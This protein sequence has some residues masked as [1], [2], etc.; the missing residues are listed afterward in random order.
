MTIE[1]DIAVDGSGNFYY[2]GAVH[3]ATGAGYYTVIEFHRYAQNL[4]DDATA[5][6][7]DLIDIT[8]ATPSDRSTDNIINILTGYTLDD[9]HGSA[10]DAISE[11]LYDGS[12]IEAD[13]TV[14]D[15]FVVIANP[16]MDLQIMQDGAQLANDYWNTIMF[17]DAS[18]NPNGYKGLNRDEPNGISH[19]FMLLVNNAGTPIDGQR[20]IGMTRVDY[21]TKE[22]GDAGTAGDGF[23]I[24]TFEIKGVFGSSDSTTPAIRT[25]DE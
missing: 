24:K 14:Y 1:T 5:S 20:V 21:S 11:H 3:G 23:S 22:S 6:G 15:G 7:D 25:S 10:T 12:I 16:D 13:G 2:T 9:G 18:Q 19:R 4:A 8:D 17:D